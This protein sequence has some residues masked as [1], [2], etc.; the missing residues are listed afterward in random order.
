MIITC[1]NCY[2]LSK[3]LITGHSVGIR[4]FFINE[5][6]EVNVHAENFCIIIKW[7]DCSDRFRMYSNPASQVSSKWKYKTT[8]KKDR[9]T[10]NMTSDLF[11]VMVIAILRLKLSLL[12]LQTVLFSSNSVDNNSD[13][14]NTSKI[15][16]FENLFSI[17]TWKCVFPQYLAWLLFCYVWN[18]EYSVNEGSI[19]EIIL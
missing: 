2:W 5:A 10:H 11:S 4:V 9:D 14:V 3:I 1:F 17:S 18:H 12:N 16:K 15:I 8:W 6:L 13:E 19:N 7:N